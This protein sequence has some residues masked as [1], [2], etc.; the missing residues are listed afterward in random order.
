MNRYDEN[1]DAPTLT[2]GSSVVDGL[3]SDYRDIEALKEGL[4]EMF[5]DTPGC[6][7]VELAAIESDTLEFQ[8]KTNRFYGAIE[9][10]RQMNPVGFAM[11]AHYMAMN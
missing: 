4:F 10:L 1:E 6:D 5:E 9:V 3:I 2:T 11:V 7:Q 8:R